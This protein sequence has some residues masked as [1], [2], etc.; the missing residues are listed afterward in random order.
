MTLNKK[1]KAIGL[2]SGGLDSVLATKLIIDQGIVVV[3]LTFSTPFFSNKNKSIV[4]ASADQLGIPLHIIELKEDYLKMIRNPNHGYGSA[5]NPC[6]DCRIFM[7]EKAKIFMEQN[8]AHFLF[9][10]EVLGQ[11]PMSQYRRSLDLIAKAS[12]LSD[13][14]LR[15]LSAKL[16]PITELEKE[17]LVDRKKLLG[18]SG[19]SRKKQ[20]ELVKKYKITTYSAPAGGC[21]LTEKGYAEKLKDLWEYKK[22][23]TL[24]EVSLLKFGRYFISKK[25]RIIVGRNKEENKEL[26]NLK[27]PSDYFFTCPSFPSPV[28]L[29]IGDKTKENIKEAAR[30]TARYSDAPNK[31]KIV[32]E[33]G[34]KELDKR[35][36]IEKR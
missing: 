22:K 14:L 35:I 11:R 30:L 6:I 9:T 2:F 28:T 5:I 34:C 1:I 12:G 19:R 20:L 3:G 32:I 13:L 7:L 10:G 33:Y 17:G 27:S 8:K 36:E 31:E 26:L 18:I 4:K 21:L 29:L 15:P 24:K 23:V 16:L 25:A